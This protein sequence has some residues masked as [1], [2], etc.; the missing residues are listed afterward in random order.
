M[1]IRLRGPQ[2]RLPIF[3]IMAVCL[4]FSSWVASHSWWL[5]AFGFPSFQVEQRSMANEY[6][7]RTRGASFCGPLLSYANSAF[8]ATVFMLAHSVAVPS[9]SSSIL[10][11]HWYRVYLVS[12]LILSLPFDQ[13]SGG[14]FHLRRYAFMCSTT[15]VNGRPTLVQSLTYVLHVLPPLSFF[16]GPRWDLLDHDGFIVSRFLPDG[17]TPCPYLQPGRLPRTCLNSSFLC[18]ECLSSCFW[19]CCS[20]TIEIEECENG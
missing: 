16:V 6:N 12:S 15:N 18:F 14:G 7:M 4:S 10:C 3:Y 13:I 5:L 1:T 9:R 8:A 11:L 19:S 20:T 17:L 2:C